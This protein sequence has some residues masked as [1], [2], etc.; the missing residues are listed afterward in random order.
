MKNTGC[1]FI[2]DVNKDRI[3]AIVGNVHRLGVI[4]SLISAMDGCKISHVRTN[5]IYLLIIK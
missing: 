4:N 1:L 3:P 5:I 2:N